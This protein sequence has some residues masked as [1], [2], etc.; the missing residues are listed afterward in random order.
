MLFYTWNSKVSW[1][2]CVRSPSFMN[3]MHTAQNDR[4]KIMDFLTTSKKLQWNQVRTLRPVPRCSRDWHLVRQTNVR[5][6]QVSVSCLLVA[7][8]ERKISRSR[9]APK[10]RERHQNVWSVSPKI[11][12]FSNYYGGKLGSPSWFIN[13]PDYLGPNST[14]T[15]RGRCRQGSNSR[16][17]ASRAVALSTRPTISPWAQS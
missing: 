17:N 2:F 14:A 13:Q 3:G 16:H 7:V 1:C 4:N 15:P 8:L 11:I 5:G 10:T 12:Q 9:K 6:V